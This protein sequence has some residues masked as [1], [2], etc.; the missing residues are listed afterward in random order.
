MKRS[1]VVDRYQEVVH[2]EI[3]VLAEY[4]HRHRG[5]IRG[6]FDFCLEPFMPRPSLSVIEQLLQSRSSRARRRVLQ[7]EILPL[8]GVR[9]PLKADFRC[10]SNSLAT[11]G[12]CSEAE[13][14]F[15]DVVD[16][17][18]DGRNRGQTTVSV[19]HDATGVPLLLKK[20]YKENSALALVPISVGSYGTLPASLLAAVPQNN[21]RK[22]V[23][24]V[25]GDRT[26]QT[27][28]VDETAFAI[29]PMRMS[30]WAYDDPLDQALFTVVPRYGN[31]PGLI[32]SIDMG[33]VRRIE[34][35]NLKDFQEAAAKV[36]QLC[37]VAA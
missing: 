16:Q 7:E 36:M 2:A 27:H 5:D 10:K 34:D 21:I 18:V 33:L 22:T 11:V 37:G 15:C 29:T 9:V 4:A 6:M 25:H 19:F 20:S 32:D 30:A 3:P 35:K 23:R 8:S 12:I 17:I 13:G 28:E 24:I 26:F 1:E 31:E 14:F